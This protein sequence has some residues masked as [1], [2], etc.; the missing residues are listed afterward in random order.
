MI[1]YKTIIADPPW[2]ERGGGKI[3]RGADRHYPLMSVRDI[4]AMRHGIVEMADPE[5]CHLYLWATNN[6]LPDAFDVMAAWGFRY[7]TCITWVKDRIGLGQYFR[8][9]TEHCLFGVMG[10][11]PY[12]TR[13]DGQRAQGTTVFHAKRKEHSRKPPDI[14]EIAE[15]VSEGPRLEVFARPPVRYGWDAWGNEVDDCQG[16]LD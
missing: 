16:V 6:Y 11:V 1:R 3:K 8:G 15:L 7:V 13:P 10:K 5:G 9:R 12:R 14:H 2:P 4:A